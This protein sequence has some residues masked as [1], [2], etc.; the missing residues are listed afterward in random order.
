M[1]REVN[2]RYRSRMKTR[3][4]LALVLSLLTVGKLAAQYFN[5]RSVQHRDERSLEL[6]PAALHSVS[7]APLA[8]ER[9]ARRTA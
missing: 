4:A 9:G 2:R 7:G 1:L 3:V 6:N 5:R 8:V